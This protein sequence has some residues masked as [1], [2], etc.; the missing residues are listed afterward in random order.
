MGKRKSDTNSSNNDNNDSNSNQ[1]SSKQTPAKRTKTNSNKENEFTYVSTQGS[2]DQSIPNNQLEL[3]RTQEKDL[4]MKMIENA[5]QFVFEPKIFTFGQDKKEYSPIY[6]FFV[7]KTV[8]SS[9]PS[10]QLEFKCIFCKKKVNYKLGES[11]NLTK[12]LQ[13]HA[14]L[15]E[16]GAVNHDQF[17]NVWFPLYLQHSKNFNHEGIYKYLIFTKLKIFMKDNYIKYLFIYI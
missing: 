2:I 15:S 11:G 5:R 17:N 14:K 6:Q 7:N 12:H 4:I 1:C 10:H 9:K 13:T 3:Q 8:F 16:D